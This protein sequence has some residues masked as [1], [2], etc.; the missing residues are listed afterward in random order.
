M[1]PPLDTYE[2]ALQFLFGRINYERLQSETYS[3]H[4]FKLDRVRWLLNLLGNPQDR[5]PA[6]HVAGTKGKGSTC[7]MLAAMLTASGRKIGLYISPHITVF[8]E[9][10]TVDGRR[11]THPEFVNLVNRVREPVAEMDNQP[12]RM[13]P[14][15]F[16]IATAMAWLY[17]LDQ[18]SE[19]AV[20]E[21]GLGGRLD[22]TNACRPLVTVI[23]NI[24]RDHTH[25]LGLTVRQIAAEKAGII[26]ERIPV[27]S[28]VS[29]PEAA[30]VIEHTAQ[31]HAAPLW[32]LGH[33]IFVETMAPDLDSFGETIWHATIRTPVNRWT[34]LRVP[35]RG[36]HQADNLALALAA[37]DRLRLAGHPITDDDARHGLAQV[38]WPARVEVLGR[39][40]TVIVDAAHNWA[41]AKA[42]VATLRH[43][44]AQHRR[45][46]VFATT[47]DKDI[48]GQLRLLLP[49]FETVILTRYVDNPRSVPPQ[50]L[51]AMVSA[52]SHQPAH[53]TED[54]V[55]AWR[56]AR[57]LA[58]PDDM[59]VVTGSF[60]L[61]AELRDV[62]LADVKDAS[63]HSARDDSAS[64]VGPRK[65]EP[66]V[67]DAG[68]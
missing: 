20:L 67:S 46:L 50:E 49:E 3:A 56:L 39:N 54:P 25:L 12:Q 11:P 42:L 37:I 41:S 16:E 53:V 48:R 55:A 38:R 45:I 47:R 65:E 10:M 63:P 5:L 57:R 60:F 15:Y 40:P 28:G 26:K 43:D 61:V 52:L 68:L 18:R 8:E 27:I 31:A 13:P 19:L 1:E 64:A 6:V 66:G 30:A 32:R 24:S 34:D 51:H 59:I 35:L 4:D 33:E 7:A 14:T 22:S 29:Q 36:R 23:T 62:I 44:F 9:R 58:D 17:F 21:T 2:Q